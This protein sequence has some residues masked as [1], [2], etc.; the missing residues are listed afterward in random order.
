MV[1]IS[2]EKAQNLSMLS[3]LSERML[4]LYRSFEAPLLANFEVLVT[5]SF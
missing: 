3:Y 4:Q 1:K 5:N 2:Q